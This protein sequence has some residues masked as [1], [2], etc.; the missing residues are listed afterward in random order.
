MVRCIVAIIVLKKPLLNQLR[1]KKYILILCSLSHLVFV[2][3]LCVVYVHMCALYA[4]V[5]RCVCVQCAVV[6]AHACACGGQRRTP[7]I[8]S[9]HFLIP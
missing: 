5:C 9:S 6:F 3:G 8:L 4:S 7:G 2:L 1:I